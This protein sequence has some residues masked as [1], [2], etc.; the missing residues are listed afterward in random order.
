MIGTPKLVGLY[1]QPAQERDIEGQRSPVTGFAVEII[2]VV[3]RKKPGGGHVFE[4]R[5]Y[6]LARRARKPPRPYSTPLREAMRHWWEVETYGA[7]V[8]EELLERG[9]G[10]SPE[11]ESRFVS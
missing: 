3:D 11:E 7:P 1:V 8:P 10:T 2:E 5:T 9:E 4:G 6:G